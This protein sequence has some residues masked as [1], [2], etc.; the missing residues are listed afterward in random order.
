VCKIWIKGEES[1][2]DKVTGFE[3][4]VANMKRAQ[5]FLK[6]VFGWKF[7]QWDDYAH[8]KTVE[9]DKNWMPKEKG[10]VNGGMFIREAKKEVPEIMI[11]VDSIDKTLE[12]VKKEKGRIMT[13]KTEAGE[14]GWWAE[15]MDTEGNIFELWEDNE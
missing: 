11:T 13:P 10:A 2:M 1:V 4:P 3:I 7:E 8:V 14:W 12:K 15:V 9:M 5:K 6:G